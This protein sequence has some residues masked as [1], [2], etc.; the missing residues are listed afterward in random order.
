MIDFGGAVLSLTRWCAVASLALPFAV[1]TAQHPFVTCSIARD[2]HVI[3]DTFRPR[4]NLRSQIR[5]AK[6]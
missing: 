5:A 1:L 4:A 3:I 6:Y 2:S